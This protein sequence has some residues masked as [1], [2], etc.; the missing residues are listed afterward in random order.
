MYG[1]REFMEAGGLMAYASNLAEARAA[2][3]R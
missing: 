1:S 3:R 2:H